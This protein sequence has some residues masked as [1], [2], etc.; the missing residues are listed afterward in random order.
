MNLVYDDESID[1][2]Q[3]N[4]LKIIQKRDGFKRYW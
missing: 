1:D 2:L 3:L 4:N